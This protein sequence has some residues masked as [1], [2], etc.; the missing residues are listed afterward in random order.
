MIGILLLF[1]LEVHIYRLTVANAT[2]VSTARLLFKMILASG[3]LNGNM[4]LLLSLKF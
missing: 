3:Q 4:H 1:Y 2:V